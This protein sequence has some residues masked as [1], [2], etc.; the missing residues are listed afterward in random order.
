MSTNYT[1]YFVVHT[2]DYVT[3]KDMNYVVE[4]TIPMVPLST[5][6]CVIIGLFLL[7]TILFTVLLLSKYRIFEKAGK[8][9]YVAIIPFYSR[10]TLFSLSDGRGWL[11]FLWLVPFLGPF[12]AL[13]THGLLSVK[14][15]NAFGK[16]KG[17]SI[18]LFLCYP[19]FLAIL[20]F[21]P[22][23]YLKHS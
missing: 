17:F 16:G 5:Y 3:T 21:G 18:G 8:P 9:G 6:G 22:S 13:W 2:V 11:S 19:V 10:F 1:D 20:A 15:S 4:P 23:L 12:L 14:L 7:L